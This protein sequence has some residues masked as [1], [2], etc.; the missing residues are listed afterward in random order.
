MKRIKLNS[1]SYPKKYA[2]VD[3]EDYDF[4]KKYKWSAGGVRKGKRPI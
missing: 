1:K 4:L 3:D 2:I